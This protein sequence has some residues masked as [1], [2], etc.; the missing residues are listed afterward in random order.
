MWFWWAIPF[1]VNVAD[2]LLD[3]FKNI[4]TGEYYSLLREDI[5]DDKCYLLFILVFGG[6][7]SSIFSFMNICCM[8]QANYFED[9]KKYSKTKW[10]W[11]KDDNIESYSRAYSKKRKISTNNVIHSGPQ[12]S[13][14]EINK[15]KNRYKRKHNKRPN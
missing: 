11:G 1:I 8:E 5:P 6:T 7:F 4:F 2:S 9:S 12:L 15:W 14:D 13:E 3:M 10:K